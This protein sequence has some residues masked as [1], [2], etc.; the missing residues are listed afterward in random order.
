MTDDKEYGVKKIKKII[1][2]ICWP[3]HR[4]SD[5]SLTN[6]IIMIGCGDVVAVQLTNWHTLHVSVVYQCLSLWK[7]LQ[8]TVTLL[9]HFILSLLFLHKMLLFRMAVENCWLLW[10]VHTIPTFSSWWWLWGI[11]CACFLFD[12]VSH[13]IICDAVYVEDA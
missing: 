2:Y 1:F 4:F 13:C 3:C 6:F 5:L 8:S 10:H 12:G 11:H 7:I 9:D